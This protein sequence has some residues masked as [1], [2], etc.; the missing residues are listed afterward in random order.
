[1]TRLAPAVG[2]H[3]VKH[4]SAFAL[5]AGLGA[6]FGAGLAVGVVAGVVVLGVFV[7]LAAWRHERRQRELPLVSSRTAAA[8]P[9][10]R[11]A[12]LQTAARAADAAQPPA[13][14]FTVGGD[15]DVAA[16]PMRPAW[17]PERPRS[18]SLPASVNPGPRSSSLPAP[19]K[20]PRRVRGTE[21]ETNTVVA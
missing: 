7:G 21:V 17:S 15:S 11:S 12:A 4:A 6:S 20:K 9:T 14:V 18:S 10:S 13:P 8:V 3:T 5:C 19:V 2:G 16:D 1:M